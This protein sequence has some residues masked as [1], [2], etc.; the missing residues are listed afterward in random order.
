[1]Q[2]EMRKSN[3]FREKSHNKKGKGEKTTRFSPLPYFLG[4]IGQPFFVNIIPQ[5]TWDVA[6]DFL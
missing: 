4:L 6:D 5:G 3:D 1:M 2:L